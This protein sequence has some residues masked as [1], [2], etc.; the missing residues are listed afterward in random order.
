MLSHNLVYLIVLS[1]VD[2]RKIKKLLL[3]MLTGDGFT[4]M[5]TTLT[6]TLV[7]LGIKTSAQM[8]RPVLLTVLLRV[9]IA[10]TG[11]TLTVLHQPV[12]HSNLAL[13]LKVSTL[14]TLVQEPT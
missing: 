2:A 13:S 12:T 7:L 6:A 5:V 3:L 9:L 8:I 11:K 10:T 1:L 4:R 14:K